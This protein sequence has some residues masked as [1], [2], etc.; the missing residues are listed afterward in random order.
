MPYAAIEPSGC[1]I[2]KN[3][4]KLRLDFFLN[5]DNPNYDKHHVYV[6][7]ETSKEYQQ[8]Y[9]GK[10]DAEGNPLDPE[11]Y[12]KWLDSL[13]HIWRDNPFHSHIL[14]IDKGIKDADLKKKIENCLNYFYQFHQHCWDESKEF[15]EEWKKVPV[16]K[17]TVRE[18]LIPGNAKDVHKHEAKVQDIVSRRDEF[19]VSPSKIPPQDLNIGEKGTIDIG[20]EAIDRFLSYASGKTC[21]SKFNPANAS[22]TLDTIE[23]YAVNNL[24]DFNV[25]TFY[26]LDATH[27]STRGYEVIGNVTSG[28]MQEFTG[29]SIDVETDDYIGFY[30]SAG[31]I[32]QDATSGVDKY[33]WDTYDDH[34]PCTNYFFGSDIEISR[35]FSCY[36]TGTEAAVGWTGKISG[37]SNPAKIMGVDVANIAKVKGVASS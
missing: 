25:A 14:R 19:R 20:A 36:G 24:S 5:S 7:D 10:V 21:V 33:Y 12:R 1:G 34:I 11:D 30:F 15:I 3:R 22:G 28:S 13:P 35:Y 23:V 6:V 16:K 32:E 27:L 37:V 29:L 8:G 4:G 9:K 2:H 26:D 18:R 17:G 31:D